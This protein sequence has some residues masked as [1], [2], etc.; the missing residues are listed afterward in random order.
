MKPT[1]MPSAHRRRLLATAGAGLAGALPIA[2]QARAQG[3]APLPGTVRIIVGSALAGPDLLARLVA[4]HL[5]A[6][7]GWNAVVENKLGAGGRIAI[8]ATKNAPPDGLTLMLQSIELLTLYPLVYRK[9]AYDSF[10]DFRPV[11]ALSSSPY[12]LAVNAAS[13]HTSLAAF[14]E[15]CKANPKLASFGTP[16]LGT[17][18]HFLGTTLGRDGG[19]EFAHVPYKGGGPAMQDLLGNQIPAIITAFGTLAAQARSGKVRILAHSA[20]QR[21]RTAPDVPTFAEQGF[22]NVVAEGDFIVATHAKAPDD[23][24]RRVSE[25]IVAQVRSDAFRDAAGK[26]G[27]EPLPAGPDVVR[28]RMQ[29]NHAHWAAVVR[30]SG[31][32]AVDV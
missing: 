29:R 24:V 31:F 27:M 26:L 4:E 1:D 8:E 18:Q 14:V 3:T 22:A 23:V 11:A 5:R 2:R 30:S 17:P 32:R 21:I 28:E 9:L 16:G 19:F 12:G 13:A 25:A 20:P 7:H 10:A 6:A 15:W